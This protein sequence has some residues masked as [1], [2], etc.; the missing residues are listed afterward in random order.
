MLNIDYLSLKNEMQVKEINFLQRKRE[1]D[2]FK[3]RNNNNFVFQKGI[4]FEISNPDKKIG[5]I[6]Q[7]NEPVNI[8]NEYQYHFIKIGEN[9]CKKLFDESL[10]NSNQ[11][12]K[13]ILIL[14]L[15]IIRKQ[16]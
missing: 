8:R 4:Y 13:I 2:H 10:D 1:N 12:E 7:K 5:N 14:L 9:S 16:I 3:E 11:K 15:Q 6:K